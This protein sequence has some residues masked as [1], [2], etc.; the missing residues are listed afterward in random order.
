MH[1]TVTAP[2]EEIGAVA[3]SP[4]RWPE[5]PLDDR[6][7]S[8]QGIRKA[9]VKAMSASLSIPHFGYKDEI[10]LNELVR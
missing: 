5:L 2:K 7:E 8:I 9:M 1:F 3:P 4:I 6:T 10:V